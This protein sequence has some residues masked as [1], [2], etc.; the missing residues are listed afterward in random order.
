MVYVGFDIDPWKME[1][2]ERLIGPRK[3]FHQVCGDITKNSFWR[4]FKRD[5][6]DL[7]KPDVVV[8]S[9]TLEHVSKKQGRRL[10]KRLRRTGCTWIIGTCPTPSYKGKQ[11]EIGWHVHEYQTDELVEMFEE[12]GWTPLEIGWTQARYKA[13]EHSEW[14]SKHILKQVIGFGDDAV[15]GSVTYFVMEAMGED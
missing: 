1:R 11:T 5:N 8:C 14:L 2:A 15:Q 13:K 3:N 9:E 6:P 7:A 10:L 12:C 4:E